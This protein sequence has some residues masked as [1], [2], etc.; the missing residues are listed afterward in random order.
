ME[1]P[2]S[3]ILSRLDTAYIKNNVIWERERRGEPDPRT[4]DER[5]NGARQLVAARIAA[6]VE[7]PGPETRDAAERG[8][9]LLLDTAR[10]VYTEIGVKVGAELAEQRLRHEREK[11]GRV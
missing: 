3:E 2:A 4:Y 9:Q 10:D 11:E 7:R 1:R 8:L 5:I 6:A